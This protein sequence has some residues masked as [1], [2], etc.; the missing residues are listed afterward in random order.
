MK[1]SKFA[2]KFSGTKRRPNIHFFWKFSKNVKPF[3]NHT[4]NSP[5][6]NKFHEPEKSWWWDVC[7]ETGVF[8]SEYVMWQVWRVIFVCHHPV[9]NCVLMKTEL[10]WYGV[11]Y[12]S[13]QVP[14]PDE[15]FTQQSLHFLNK[16]HQLTFAQSYTNKSL[17]LLFFHDMIWAAVFVISLLL[18]DSRRARDRTIFRKI[19]YDA[20]ALHN[21]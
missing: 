18:C 17:H 16:T 3:L 5:V 12:L 15:L 21:T 8:I 10:C 2:V 9:S 13:N 6:W 7:G 14:Q 11:I 4:I 19:N 20:L 1:N